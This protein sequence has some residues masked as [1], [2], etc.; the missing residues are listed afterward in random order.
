MYKYDERNG[1]ECNHNACVRLVRYRPPFGSPQNMFTRRS[2]FIPNT[3]AVGWFRRSSRL[4]GVHRRR[5][6][7]RRRRFVNICCPAYTP[8]T[9]H[10]KKTGTAC[11]A[12]SRRCRRRRFVPGTACRS[13][14]GRPRTSS[15][16]R[17]PSPSASPVVGRRR[18]YATCWP[19]TAGTPQPSRR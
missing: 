17:S 18:L 15:G 7:R 4:G 11:P 19:C 3:T 9:G 1:T 14:P 12:S 8:D 16:R 6:R 5:R 10:L 2:R 13:A